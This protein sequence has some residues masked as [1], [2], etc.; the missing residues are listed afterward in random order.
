M[1]SRPTVIRRI[2][3]STDVDTQLASLGEDGR[4]EQ[5]QWEEGRAYHL[6]ERAFVT[7]QFAHELMSKQLEKDQFNKK[8]S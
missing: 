5:R 1:K 2:T 3:I 4:N 8:L 6:A 7:A